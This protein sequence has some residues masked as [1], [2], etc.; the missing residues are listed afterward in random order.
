MSK[1]GQRWVPSKCKWYDD[2]AQPILG[3]CK[4]EKTGECPYIHPPDDRFKTATRWQT[5]ERDPPRGRGRGR[6][7]GGSNSFDSHSTSRAS[8]SGWAGRR[9]SSGNYGGDSSSRNN[10]DR[11]NN[12]DDD[13][14]VASWKPSSN[15]DEPEASTSKGSGT[16]WGGWGDDAKE[17][18][19][20]SKGS[21]TGWGGWGEDASTSKGSGTAW[22]SWGDDSNSKKADDKDESSKK[23][24]DTWAST[25]DSNTWGG[26]GGWGPEPTADKDSTSKTAVPDAWTPSAPPLTRPQGLQVDTSGQMDVSMPPPSASS[27]HWRAGSQ[28]PSER[29]ISTPQSTFPSFAVPQFAKEDKERQ[30]RGSK[31]NLNNVQIHEAIIRGTI[32]MTCIELELRSLHRERER[33]KKVQGSPQFHRITSEAGAMLDTKR[34]ALQD[35]IKG[36]EK[37]LFF[38]REELCNFP[39]LPSVGPNYAELE[40]EIMGFTEQLKMWLNSFTEAVA[41][42]KPPKSE[43]APMDVDIDSEQDFDPFSLVERM[44]QRMAQLDEALEDAEQMIQEPEMTPERNAALVDSTIAEARNRANDSSNME[45][46]VGEEGPV[47]DAFTSARSNDEQVQKL[48]AELEQQWA[49]TVQEEKRLK[50]LDLR[51]Q[52]HLKLKLEM[53]AQLEKLEIGRQERAARRKIMNMELRRLG[54]QRPAPTFD[55]AILVQARA[56]AESMITAEVIPALEALGQQYSGAIEVRM[57]S[58]EAVVQPTVDKTD[59]ICRRAEMVQ[60]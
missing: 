11:N 23:A 48:T 50:A 41:A 15:R 53:E 31:D 47:A 37:R 59:E 26:G 46:M 5:A 19:S 12:R 3:G 51:K 34:T 20:P 39:E 4:K 32:R 22:G 55:E 10:N 49:K 56:A 33:L 7:R 52:K 58:L 45:A 17:Q 6:G 60:G 27:S 2:D 8:D 35:K 28:G 42:R 14:D 16:G 38:A 13:W 18:A 44:E 1:F 24:G 36:T 40:K 57:K 54:A 43:P 21:D 30:R 9:Q 25:T 29:V